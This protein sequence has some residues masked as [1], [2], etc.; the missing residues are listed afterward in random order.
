[1]RFGDA[2]AT[3]DFDSSSDFEPPRKRGKTG[4]VDPEPVVID[5]GIVDP[6]PVIVD[7]TGPEPVIVDLTGPEP[8]IVDLTGSEPVI[9]LT[10][11]SDS[12]GEGDCMSVHSDLSSD[13]EG[14]S[15]SD[16][17]DEGSVDLNSVTCASPLRESE[18][19]VSGTGTWR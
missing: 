2:E 3:S 11:E 7:L 19:W 6:E 10:G 4:V 8:V 12:E 1:M 13:D 18:T 5:W 9:D 15:D 17:S 16:V 14:L